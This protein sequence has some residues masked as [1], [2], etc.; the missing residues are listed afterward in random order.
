MISAL[1]VRNRS[2]RSHFRYPTSIPAMLRFGF[3]SMPVVIR[4]VSARGVLIDIKQPP[5]CG[6]RVSITANGL[7]VRG[8]I[9]WSSSTQ[10]GIYFDEE[11][12]PLEIVRKNLLA[13]PTSQTI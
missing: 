2:L 6:S 8:S 5:N 7:D 13:K 10:C 11:V 12:D 4:D 1:I 9:V 3:V